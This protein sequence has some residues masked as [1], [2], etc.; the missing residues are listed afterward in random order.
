MRVAALLLAATILTPQE[1]VAPPPSR[2]FEPWLQE[3]IAE[4]RARGFSDELIDATL[5]GITPIQR[6][7]ERDSSQGPS[8]AVHQMPAGNVV[9][10]DT[11]PY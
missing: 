10:V 8:R 1:T 4:A 11:A 2:P 6:V 7:V 5:S 9:S 3:L